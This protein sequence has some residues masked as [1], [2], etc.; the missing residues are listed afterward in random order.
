MRGQLGEK[1]C[2]ASVQ[3]RQRPLFNRTHVHDPQWKQ[4]LS[5]QAK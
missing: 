5:K 3:G 2:T 1:A 4:K